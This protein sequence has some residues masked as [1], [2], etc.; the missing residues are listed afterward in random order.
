MTNLGIS[1][2]VA[3]H[4]LYFAPDP[5][6][7]VVCTIGGNVAENPAARTARKYGFTTN[8]V[9]GLTMVC[10]RQRGHP[11]RRLA[12][13]G[14]A[15]PRAVVVGSEGTLGIV[16][17]VTAVAAQARGDPHAGRRLPRRG[18]AGNAVSDI[19]SAGIIRPPSRC[20][21]RWR[22]KRVRG[23]RRRLLVRHTRRAGG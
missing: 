15:G 7:Q 14:R 16:T 9:L 20:W 22:S 2:A 18:Q 12:G 13:S 1:A 8:H 23:D 17:E 10:R 3:P 21:T 4:G 11:G 5:S 19:V 6:S